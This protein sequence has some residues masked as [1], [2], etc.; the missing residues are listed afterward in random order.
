MPSLRHTPNMRRSAIIE[1]VRIKWGILINRDKAYRVRVAATEMLQGASMDQYAHVRKYATELLRSNP[2]STISIKT[3]DQGDHA[4]FER[5]YVCFSA[6]KHAFARHCRPLI[7]LDGCFLKGLYGGQLLTAV[8]KDGNNQMFPIAYA[9]VE[10]ET[11]DSWDWFVHL[12]MDD[13]NSV[14][15]KNWAFISDQQK[16][17]IVFVLKFWLNLM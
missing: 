3:I 12:L 13:L 16:V 7:G 1:E 17:T 2:G 9:V 14:E 11:S 10:A 8:G 4:V 5:L 15:S 6:T